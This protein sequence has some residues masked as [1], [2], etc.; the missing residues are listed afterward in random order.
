M[1]SRRMSRRVVAS[2]LLASSLLGGG[3]AFAASLS[4][5]SSKLTVYHRSAGCAA[6]T[7]TVTAVA[8]SYIDQNSANTNFGTAAD[9]KIRPPILITL[10]GVRRAL[11]RFAL[12]A[13]PDLCSVASVKLRL[14]TTAWVTGQT[15]SVIQIADPWSE[16]G[17]GS[18]TW[19]NQPGTTGGTATLSTTAGAGWREWTVTALYSGAGNGFM[20]RDLTGLLTQPEQVFDSRENTHDPELA[21]TFS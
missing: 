10:L 12:P 14:W 6:G 7:T 13:T 21:V 18:V 17:T 19:T 8:D 3:V 1:T 5:S 11:V 16:S 20:I 4:V 9:L 2:V 15:L